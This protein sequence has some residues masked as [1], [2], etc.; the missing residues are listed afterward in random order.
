MGRERNAVWLLGLLAGVVSV[1]ALATP[2][3]RFPSSVVFAGLVGAVAAPFVFVYGPL[4][5]DRRERGWS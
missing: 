4:F 3:V 2:G 1:L 5:L